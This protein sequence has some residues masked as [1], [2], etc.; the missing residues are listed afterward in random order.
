M[1]L[2]KL[3]TYITTRFDSTHSLTRQPPCQLATRL[4]WPIGP[5]CIESWASS[6]LAQVERKVPVACPARLLPYDLQLLAWSPASLLGPPWSQ[7]L[8]LGF[9]HLVL[10]CLV[11]WSGRVPPWVLQAALVK[12]WQAPTLETSLPPRRCMRKS[13]LQINHVLPSCI[14]RCN[15]CRMG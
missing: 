13:C 15:S 3:I 4:T 10:V 7:L 1:Y 11:P 6:V 14:T 2:K 8:L 9:H 12:A 5:W